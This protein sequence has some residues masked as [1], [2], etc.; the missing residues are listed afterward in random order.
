MSNKTES[1]IELVDTILQSDNKV[2]LFSK[3]KTSA[4]LIAEDIQKQLKV[5]TLLYTGNESDVERDNAIDLFKN[6]DEYNVL[7][8]TEAMSTGLNIQVAKYMI[9]I[10]QPDTLAIKTQRI[11][12]I[13]RVGSVYDN[14]IV[15]D[16]ITN[17]TSKA[18]SK[19]EERLQN[20][21]NNKDLTDA[22]VSIDESQR[23]ALIESMKTQ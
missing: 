12:R 23:K 21:E 3:F 2:I 15:Y 19:D 14:V 16:M 9:N 13:R 17:S 8:G 22:L 18:H 20:I 6:S 1:I 10:D 11:G 7:I 4:L 5:K